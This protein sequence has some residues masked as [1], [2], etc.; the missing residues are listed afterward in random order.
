MHCT[1]L[2][3]VRALCPQ[4][5]QK[6]TKAVIFTSCGNDANKK[7]TELLCSQ[8]SKSRFEGRNDLVAVLR[9]HA[10]DWTTGQGTRILL[11]VVIVLVGLVTMI[12]ISGSINDVRQRPPI[13][14][15]SEC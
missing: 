1:P 4:Q 11:F 8:G 9:V 14:H 2:T 7:K 3:V 5:T 12:H 10:M 13:Q 6:K 15:A